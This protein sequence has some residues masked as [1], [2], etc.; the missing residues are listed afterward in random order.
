MASLCHTLRPLHAPCG[1][2]PWSLH[3]LWC[4][5]ARFLIPLTLSYTNCG[6]GRH[7]FSSLSFPHSPSVVLAGTFPYPSD[8]LIHHLCCWQAHFLIVFAPPLSLLFTWP[9]LSL[10]PLPGPSGSSL[11]QLQS[12]GVTNPVR[13]RLVS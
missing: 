5:Q 6:A 9:Q 11:S 8:S 10:A 7:V 2:P 12:L 3:H 1:L 4:W 13:I